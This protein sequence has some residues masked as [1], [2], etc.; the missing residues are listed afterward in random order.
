MFEFINQGEISGQSE[1]QFLAF[2]V[3]SPGTYFSGFRDADMDI[4]VFA[5]AAGRWKG[6]FIHV[7]LLKL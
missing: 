7:T 3:Q 4:I 1:K 6:L 5:H 2:G